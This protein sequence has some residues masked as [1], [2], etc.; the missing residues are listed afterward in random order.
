MSAVDHRWF[1]EESPEDFWFTQLDAIALL[2]GPVRINGNGM[3]CIYENSNSYVGE[4]QLRTRLLSRKSA[5]AEL[6]VAN[7][8]NACDILKLYTLNK[9]NFLTTSLTRMGALVGPDSSDS[10]LQYSFYTSRG[11]T[12]E[13][14]RFTTRDTYR[15]FYRH[16]IYF[17]KEL[18][19]SCSQA[20]SGV[21]IQDIRSYRYSERRLSE[22]G[23]FSTPIT[24]EIDNCCIYEIYAKDNERSRPLLP[25]NSLLAGK[26]SLSS[27]LDSYF[28]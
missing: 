3:I 21:L 22:I 27:K 28:T 14:A 18:L 26:H 20:N 6:H 11:G 25:S 7:S 1:R 9:R 12:L 10:F 4:T 19:I 13:A 5:N 23:C 2:E 15:R 16:S 17:S 24:K 8:T